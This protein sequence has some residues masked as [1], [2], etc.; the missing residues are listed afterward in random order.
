MESHF[1]ASISGQPTGSEQVKNDNFEGN[2]FLIKTYQSAFIE[3]L[4]I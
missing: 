1:G 2:H 4:S 3:D